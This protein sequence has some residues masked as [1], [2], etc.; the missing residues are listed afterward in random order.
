MILV[1]FIFQLLDTHD[2]KS[3]PDIQVILAQWNSGGRAL[4]LYIEPFATFVLFCT[5]G[6]SS[7][8]WQT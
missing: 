4:L 5:G 2:I 3:D 6:M 1:Q 7:Y 8:T